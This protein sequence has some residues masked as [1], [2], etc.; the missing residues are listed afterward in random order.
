MYQGMRMAGVAGL[1]VSRVIFGRAVDVA[2]DQAAGGGCMTIVKSIE[3]LEKLYDA[4]RFCIN[5]VN[6]TA[7]RASRASI[8]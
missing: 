5:P 1:G 3:E 8:V 4:P 6:R 2:K 7:Q